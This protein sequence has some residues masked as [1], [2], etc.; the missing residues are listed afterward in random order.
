MK[1][2]EQERSN[3]AFECVSKIKGKP[4]EKDASS[5]ISKLGTLI[6]TNGLG[7][8][9][10]FL[11]AKGKDHHLEVIAI[12]SNWLFRQGGQ[13][14]GITRDDLKN[15]DKKDKKIEEIMK[16]LV[17]DVSVEQYMYYTD[18]TLRLVNWLRRF[19]DAMLESGGENEQG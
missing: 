7:N 14:L 2:L 15:K 3:Y 10:A 11:F 13:N 1:T 12:I 16:R 17:L 8:T 5:L 4:F 18:E 6:L 9:L 19:S